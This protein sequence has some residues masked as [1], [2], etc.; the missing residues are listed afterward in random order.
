MLYQNTFLLFA[1]IDFFF[2][3]LTGGSTSCKQ[4]N[5]TL[6]LSPY[7]HVNLKHEIC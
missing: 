3:A 4:T 6:T 1:S 5:T 2:F 7:K